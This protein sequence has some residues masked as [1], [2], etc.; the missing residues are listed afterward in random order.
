VAY[1]VG[2]LDRGLA[3]VVGI[4]LTYSR[5]TV[6]LSAAASMTRAA[7]EVK[8][9]A[10]F[11]EAFGMPI[12][13]FPLLAGQ[14]EEI[15]RAAKRTTAGAFR[16]YREFIDMG[17]KLRGGLNSEEPLEQRKK[18]FRFRELVMLQKITGAW[19][20]TETLHNAMSVLGGHGVMEDFSSL[21]RLYRDS[22]VNELWEGPRNVLL[23]QMHRD[24]QRVAEWY[25]PGEVAAD[26]LE[27]VD[28]E[29]VETFSREAEELVGHP[30]LFQMDEATKD[31]CRRW[32]RFCHELFHAY[33]EQALARVL[34]RESVAAG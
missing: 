29:K 9:Y 3:N 10:G 26:I 30:N 13:N 28:R 33:Q 11:R 32:D 23:T 21:P 34:S 4:V 6:G 17:G 31:V 19:D 24:M 20:S 15:D 8:K 14:I 22:A 7:R 12:G 1:P 5:L 2:P 27:G 18:N 16:L 25:P